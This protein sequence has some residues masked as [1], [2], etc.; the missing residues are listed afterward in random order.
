[1][2]VGNLI[3]YPPLNYEL[4]RDKS[5]YDTLS[6]PFLN[7]TFSSSSIFQLLKFYYNFVNPYEPYCNYQPY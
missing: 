6:L 2:I 1:M 3:L 5:V 4:S 7:N